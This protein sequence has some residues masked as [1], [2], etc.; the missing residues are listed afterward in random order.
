MSKKIV[1]IVKSIP[2]K[3]YA[4]FIATGTIFAAI[5]GIIV[6]DHSSSKDRSI[7]KEQIKVQK[8]EKYKDRKVKTRQLETQKE[9]QISQRFSSAIKMLSDDK[10]INR[11]GGIQEL[12]EIA[13]TSP[14]YHWK[15][16]ETLSIF[17]QQSSPLSKNKKLLKPFPQDVQAALKA[18]GRRDITQDPLDAQNRTIPRV[19]LRHLNLNNADL[20]GARLPQAEISGSNLSEAKLMGANLQGAM[21]WGVNLR[22]AILFQASLQGANFFGADLEGAI[23]DG[24]DITGANFFKACNIT[25]EQ[26]KKTSNWDKAHFE[27]SFRTQLGLPAIQTETQQLEKNTELLCSIHHK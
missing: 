3:F 5:V 13:K 27:N 16:V 24:A 8:E 11:I 9:G 22:K 23:L 25:T 12:E 14:G 6:T 18:V 2:K 17:I 19:D 26:I 7:Q 20:T 4:G 10:I 1:E 21:L 15:T